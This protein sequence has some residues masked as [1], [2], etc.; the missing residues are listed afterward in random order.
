MRRQEFAAVAFATALLV[1]APPAMAQR[2]E[3]TP[4]GTA[5]PRGGGGGGGGGGTAVPRGGDGGSSASSSSSV[6]TSSTSPA[7]VAPASPNSDFRV[8]GPATMGNP[9]IEPLAFAPQRRGGGGGGGSNGGGGGQAVPR[10][11]GGGSA[12]PSSPRSGSSAP[13][14]SSR[15]AGP[16]GDSSS[17]RGN[18]VPAYSR[19][20]EGQP[21]HGEAVQRTSPPNGGGG[22]AIYPPYWYY[23][24]PYY[25]YYW[26]SYGYGLS[27]LYDPWLGFGAMYG[28][29]YPYS[30]GYDPYGYGYGG[31]SGYVGG[32]SSG[33]GSSSSRDPR[34]TGGLRL[35]IKPREAQVYVDGYLAGDVDSFDGSFQKLDIQSGP[36]KIE[37]KADGYE[38]LQFDVLITAG[39]TSTFKGEM[40]RIK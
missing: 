38:P 39:E 15:A 32:Y 12:A 22:G 27:Y 36:H 23:G 18:A 3:G 21:S 13:A 5:E 34:D 16:S 6:T 2:P 30:Y 40:K 25:P 19:P 1:A 37:L 7:A 9:S 26:G 20:R 35:K 24:Y 14:G 8:R 17:N 11:S 28:Y 31:G 4:V 33:G 29:G 10:S